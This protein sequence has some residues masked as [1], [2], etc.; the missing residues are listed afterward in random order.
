MRIRNK[1]T[2]S[3]AHSSSFNT[4]SIGEIIVLFED[5]DAD[6]DY[7]RNYDVLLENGPRAKRWMDLS[8]AFRARDVIPNNYNTNFAEPCSEEDRSRG[9][10][11]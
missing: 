8:E 1:T 3:L 9:Y 10:S 5:G 2:M 7:I 4:N 11:L 6:S